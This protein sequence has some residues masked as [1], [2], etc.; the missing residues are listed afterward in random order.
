VIRVDVGEKFPIT[1][2]L[3]DE[4]TGDAVTGEVV[5]YDI[6]T[7]D[8]LPLSPTVSGI[9]PE[10]TSDPGIYRTEISLPTPGNYICYVRATGFIT[11]TEEVL[12]ND[13]S[14]KDLVKQ[15]RHYNISVEHVLRNN[16]TPT[17]SQLV[18]NVPLSK[19]DYII[20]KIKYDYDTDWLSTTTS[21]VVYAWYHSVNDNVPYKMG[22]SGV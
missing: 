1:V 13:E 7:T 19:T 12:V 22:P 11:S 21:G 4:A 10:S 18:R 20:T 9:V 8:D 14:L 3:V 2:A 5:V 6:R 17:P 15:N 16:A